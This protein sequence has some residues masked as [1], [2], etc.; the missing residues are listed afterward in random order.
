MRTTVT[1]VLLA[2]AMLGLG[3]APHYGEWSKW[4]SHPAGMAAYPPSTAVAVVL[5]P[6]GIEHRERI[7]GHDERVVPLGESVFYSEADRD[8]DGLRKFAR[9]IGADTAG[10][11]VELAAKT[12]TRRGLVRGG[13]VTTCEVF[14]TYW[15]HLDGQQQGEAR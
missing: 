1:V 12:V 11:T 14:A 15:R 13:S 8:D 10:L 3:C 6:P 7:A 5:V 4:Y 9:H 2:V